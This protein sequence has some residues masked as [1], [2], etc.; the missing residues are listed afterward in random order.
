MFP[1][2][3]EGTFFYIVTKGI[4]AVFAKPSSYFFLCQSLLVTHSHTCRNLLYFVRSSDNFLKLLSITIPCSWANWDKFGQ[5]FDMRE[6]QLSEIIVRFL[7]YNLVF[8]KIKIVEK[9]SVWT[10]C[11]FTKGSCQMVQNSFKVFRQLRQEK[12]ASWLC[13]TATL[14]HMDSKRTAWG[15]H[16]IGLSFQM[17]GR[18]FLKPQL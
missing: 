3:S 1:L 10:V 8:F 13:K 7:H 17:S 9:I 5:E 14:L 4:V 6:D 16:S 12:L 2:R 15:L 11:W 18:P